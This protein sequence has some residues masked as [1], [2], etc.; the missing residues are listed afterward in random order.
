MKNEN[1]NLNRFKFKSIQIY[2]SLH[3]KGLVLLNV[4]SNGKLNAIV[5]RWS[6]DLC[7]I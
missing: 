4:V 7:P 6:I 5:S 1:L 3:P 2:H